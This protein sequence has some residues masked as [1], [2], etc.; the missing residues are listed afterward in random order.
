MID[1]LQTPDSVEIQTEENN[2]CSDQVLVS[3]KRASYGLQVY[4]QSLEERVR[5]IILHWKGNFSDDIKVL[6]DVWTGFPTYLQWD[7]DFLGKIFSWYLM[8][9]FGGTYQGYGVMTQARAMC[10]WEIRRTEI[11]LYLDVRCGSIGVK[12]GTRKLHAATIVSDKYENISSHK[13]LS[14]FCRK[15]C[16]YAI[17]PDVPIYG[18]TG[19]TKN[20]MKKTRDELCRD[21]AYLAKL[22]E[23]AQN[24]P[25]YWINKND[26]P[27]WKVLA[28][29]ICGMRLN[30]GI[31]FRPLLESLKEVP[32][33]ATL[34]N[35]SALDPSHPKIL[36][37]VGTNVKAMCEEGFSL[38]I[39]DGSVLDIFGK[40]EEEGYPFSVSGNW[41]FYDEAKTSAEI[42]MNF[43]HTIREAAGPYGA[44]IMG[45][46]TI[47]HLGTGFMH[48]QTSETIEEMLHS[49]DAN[50]TVN[51]VA[52]RFPQHRNFFFVQEGI[53]EINPLLW[54]KIRPAAQMIACSGTPLFLAVSNPE[55]ITP[56]E[57]TDMVEILI[58][59]S[60]PH[61]AIEAV[62]WEQKGLMNKVIK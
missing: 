26:V 57:E 42:M 3:F 12:L 14:L 24:R 30:A 45:C 61:T 4:C 8:A 25:Y 39:F 34:R 13:A 44:I 27:D 18:F 51:S 58:E 29:D 54:K 46:N 52:F 50:L 9:S 15:M 23:G 11:V 7:N 33:E 41:H 28:S 37:K 22:T 49:E 32:G 60:R 19:Y 59:A 40:T 62:D 56:D 43:Y 10:F 53:L 1:I 5:F 6:G 20:R 38:I 55:E 2:K 47:G 36:K 35:G 16:G 48:I 17:I 31:R 21:A